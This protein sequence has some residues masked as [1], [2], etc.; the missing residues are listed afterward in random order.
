M[1][2][3]QKP[4]DC[5]EISESQTIHV[6]GG[7]SYGGQGEQHTDGPGNDS[8]RDGTIRLKLGRSRGE[9]GRMVVKGRTTSGGGELLA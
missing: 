6:W 9:T 5:P 3:G 7:L 2:A 4:P 1:G 8:A